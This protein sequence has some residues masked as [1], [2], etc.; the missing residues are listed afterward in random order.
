MEYP[1][2]H[3]LNHYLPPVQYLKVDVLRL[4]HPKCPSS[5]F[6]TRVTD[7]TGQK[8][9]I[10]LHRVAS[11]FWFKNRSGLSIAPILDKFI[12][13]YENTYHEVLLLYLENNARDLHYRFNIPLDK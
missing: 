3:C 8:D 5:S 13:D 11:M 1:L 10:Q 12:T 6:L 4:T 9:L 7:G 2:H